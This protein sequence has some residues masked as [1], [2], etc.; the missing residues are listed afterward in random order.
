MFAKAVAL[1]P[2]DDET[3]RGYWAQLSHTKKFDD[4]IKGRRDHPGHR[5][6]RLEAPLERGGAMR[7]AGKKTEAQAAFSAINSDESRCVEVRRRAKK[8]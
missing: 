5:Q 8:R 1:A 3:P 2:A 6:A 4:V 7:G